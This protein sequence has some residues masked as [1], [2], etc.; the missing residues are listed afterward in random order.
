MT[1][2]HVIAIRLRP[3][4]YLFWLLALAA[5]GTGFVSEF[6]SNGAG[7]SSL[8]YSSLV[9]GFLFWHI[10]LGIALFSPPQRM[11]PPG[12]KFLLRANLALRRFLRLLLGALWLVILV[13]ILVYLRRGVYMT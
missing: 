8:G 12:S 7:S 9:A 2:L 11:P 4:R 6:R 3:F 13:A 10:S 1:L 5:F